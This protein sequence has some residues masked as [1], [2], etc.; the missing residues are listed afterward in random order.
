MPRISRYFV[1]GALLYLVIGFT[2]GAIILANKGVS[3][4]PLAWALL[5]VHIEL[6]LSGWFLQLAFGVAY[7]ILPR[8]S[9]GASRGNP[10]IAWIGFGL[11]NIG[12]LLVV[13]DVFLPTNQ[14]T[15]IGRIFEAVGV[16]AFVL[17]AWKRIKPFAA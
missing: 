6:L 16:A 12:I 11:L 14:L 4:F 10:T 3:L 17:A 1:H 5:P 13:L 8:F 15:S 2:L 7:W 9:K